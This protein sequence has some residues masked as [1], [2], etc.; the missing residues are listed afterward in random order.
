VFGAD[1]GLANWLQYQGIKHYFTMRAWLVV[2]ENI[3]SS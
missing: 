1:L 2:I 3:D